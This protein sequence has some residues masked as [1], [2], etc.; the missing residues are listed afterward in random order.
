MEA[1]DLGRLLDGSSDMVER[2]VA[3]LGGSRIQAEKKAYP[4]ISYENY[5]PL[6]FSFCYNAATN[7]PSSN[8]RLS[9]IDIFNPP[10][11]PMDIRKRRKE[12]WFG[13][14]A[15]RFPIT[16]RFSNT[17]VPMPQL[18]T[19]DHAKPAVM[20]DIERDLIFEVDRTTTGTEFVGHFGEPTKKGEGETG[21][22]PTFLEWD[23]VEIVD[24]Q[25]NKH[26]MGV[27]FE[28][29]DDGK[30]G[31]GGA[32]VW[33]RAGGWVWTSLKLFIPDVKED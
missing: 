3:S 25:G 32:R 16:F 8:E 31:D 10:T 6:G 19:P 11:D 27:M 20:K 18:K 13:Y 5:H 30:G 14:D 21:Y 24:R 12:A 15:P 26:T 22:V 17:K 2:Y 28:L 4:D 29:R 1:V 23:R 9:Y 33:D 7:S